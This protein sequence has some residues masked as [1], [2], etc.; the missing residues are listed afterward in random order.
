MVS[1]LESLV[2]ANELTRRSAVR[3]DSNF[4]GYFRCIVSTEAEKGVEEVQ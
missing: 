2:Q 1:G 3:V 4:G